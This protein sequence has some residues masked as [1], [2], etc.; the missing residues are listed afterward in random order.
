MLMRLGALGR[1]THRL[2]SG[3]RSLRCTP[4]VVVGW[5]LWMSMLTGC[6]SIAPHDE[7]LASQIS[8]TERIEAV[9][10]TTSDTSAASAATP[11]PDNWSAQSR[12]GRE[13]LLE[14]DFETAEA[15]FLSA[16]D[17]SKAFRSRDVRVHVSFGNLVRLA[18]VYERV[19]RLYDAKR[20][21][22]LIESSAGQRRIATRRLARYRARYKTLVASALDKRLEP[23]SKST[24]GTQRGS[25]PYDR[26]IR[27]TAD[28][29]D[30]DPA[31]IKAVVA[32]ESN[33]KPRA[34][35]RV[36]AQGLMQL[37]PATARAMGVRR[38]FAPSENIRGGVRYLR[39][40]LDRFDKIDLALAAYNAGP[41]AVMR[42][43]GI[44][45]YAETEAYVTKVLSHYRRYQ[46]RFS[47]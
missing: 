22:A 18:S 43:G 41:E 13:A 4:I 26:L 25:A 32:A 33:F 7:G 29:F 44:P 38:P 8:G 19:G 9:Q 14:A 45:P 6:A 23:V 21:M 36:G 3:S 37:M 16:L 11:F 24:R 35:S 17:G 47:R 1:V 31:L 40:L 12:K 10:F 39:S 34:V 27:N 2:P 20:V 15:L 46:A 42:H 28:S 5:A 30:I